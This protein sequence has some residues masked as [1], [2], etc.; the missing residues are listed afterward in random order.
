MSQFTLRSI[1]EML[2]QMRSQASQDS[3]PATQTLESAENSQQI[4]L[5]QTPQDSQPQT[6]KMYF[7][8]VS[9]FLADLEDNKPSINPFLGQTVDILTAFLQE[10]PASRKIVK[11]TGPK[12]EPDE[13]ETKN[14]PESQKSLAELQVSQSR[15]LSSQKF[16]PFSSVTD[17]PALDKPDSS[18]VALLEQEAMLKPECA[19]K[20]IKR[21]KTGK[22]H[23]IRYES[24]RQTQQFRLYE[25]ENAV[26][27]IPAAFKDKLRPIRVDDDCDTD[28]AEVNAAITCGLMGLKCGYD[29][30][31][32]EQKRTSKHT[33]RNKSVGAVSRNQ[34]DKSLGEAKPVEKVTKES[35]GK[36]NGHS[37]I[38]TGSR[39]NRITI[40]PHIS[41][42]NYS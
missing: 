2:N 24:K 3:K 20:K 35:R 23:K 32:E 10:R 36:R 31:I 26:L 5:S 6:A 28:E 22:G 17:Q 21:G 1:H 16:N 37:Q 30:E 29:E 13:N 42:K 41:Q 25:K 33:G 34:R 7:K 39:R 12:N 9:R 4:F 27:V 18:F 19:T 11:I 40:S 38:P 8:Q 15:R 14:E